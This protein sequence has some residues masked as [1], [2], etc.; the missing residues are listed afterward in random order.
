M[1]RDDVH[2]IINGTPDHWHTLVNLRAVKTGKD[3]YS[4]KP[5]TL[6]IDEGKHLLKAVRQ[7]KTVFQVG[8]QQR[9]DKNFRLA[10]E[11]VR[12]GRLGKLQEIMVGLPTGPR[13]GPFE[14]IPVPPNLDW[15]FY[16]S[17]EHTSELQSHSDLVCRLLLE[18]KKKTK[19]K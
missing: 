19:T 14:P 1:E 13:E 12:N 8:S 7:Y 15:D 5:L 17:E 11:L 4:E 2:I 18:K 3:I 10:C 9:S 6:T 16:R